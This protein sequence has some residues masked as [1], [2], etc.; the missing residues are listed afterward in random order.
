MVSQSGAGT[1]AGLA[2]WFCALGCSG[3]PEDSGQPTGRCNG[4]EA[5]CDVTFDELVVAM[6]HNAM[7]NAEE[8][9]LAPNQ[10]LGLERQLEDGIRGFMLDTHLGDG[11]EALLCHGLCDLGSEPLD[12][13]L[14]KF[15]SFLEENPGE[16]VVFMIQNG[17]S[18]AL[19]SDAFDAAGLTRYTY[20][21]SP[22]EPWPTLAALVDDNTRLVVFHEGGGTEFGWYMD[23]YGEHVWDTPYGQDSPEA[24]G[25]DRLRGDSE[26]PLFL[27]NHFLTSP[28]AL[29]E[30]AE[31]VNY[32]PFLIDRARQCEAES[33]Q[34]V[35]WIAVDFYDIGDVV[36]A[37]DELN[38]V[39]R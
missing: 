3:T 1:L 36:A 32:N 10:N 35:N 38:G 12:E 16:V 18:A 30:L 4:H 27:M 5:L 26:H 24:M 33:G 11:G 6:T 14:A 28:I 39:E 15:T 25:C 22:G 21:H 2:V 17:I 31:Q 19:T 9:W 37:V 8:G 7:S 34:R 13:G 23:G 29:P 20:S